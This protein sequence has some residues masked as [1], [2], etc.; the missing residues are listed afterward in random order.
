MILHG[1]TMIKK[2]AA[3]IVLSLAFVSKVAVNAFMQ[4]TCKFIKVI[5]W[6]MCMDFTK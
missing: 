3:I 4:L 5:S 1:A 6:I 2:I